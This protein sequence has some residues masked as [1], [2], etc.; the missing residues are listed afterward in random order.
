[1][2]LHRLIIEIEDSL[3]ER[4]TQYLRTFPVEKVKILKE[5]P[6]KAGNHEAIDFS[7]YTIASLQNIS[8]PI[9]RQREFRSDWN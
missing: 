7:K 8:D 6:H 2:L 9:S 1:V 5:S 4:V 3:V